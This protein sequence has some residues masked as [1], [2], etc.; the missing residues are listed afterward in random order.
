[1]LIQQ[2]AR[3]AWWIVIGLAA[4]YIASFVWIAISTVNYPFQLEWL[5]GG[6]VDVIQRVVTGR[7]IYVEPSLEYVPYVYMPLYYWLAALVTEVVGIGLLAP[8]L[9]SLVS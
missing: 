8:R 7:G 3:A 4:W 1:M 5:E 9:V 2:V 6:T